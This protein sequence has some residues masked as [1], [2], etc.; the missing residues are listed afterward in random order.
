VPRGVCLRVAFETLPVVHVVGGR[1][2]E[3]E[4][5][6]PERALGALAKRFGK[7]VLVDAEGI[8]RNE[9]QVEFL[10]AAAHRRSV[11]VDAGSRYADDAMDLFVAGAEAVTMRWNTL[12][13]P[14]ELADA[15]EIAQPGALFLGLEWPKGQFLRHRHDARSA[16]DVVS[17]ATAH[18]VGIVH[19]LDAPDEHALR[20]LPPGSGRWAQ[21]LPRRLVAAAQEMGFEGAMLPPAEIPPEEA[22]A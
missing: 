3:Y 20:A 12:H 9:P 17:W 4:G 18:G 11:W 21:G 2:P 5:Q 16:E 15:A 7:L 8:Q 19:V 13:R 14:D 10:Q 6:D 22:A 1:F